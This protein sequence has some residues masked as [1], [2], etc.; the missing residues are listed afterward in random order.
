M[1]RQDWVTR[2]MKD[3]R[4]RRDRRYHCDFCAYTCDRMAK[5]ERHVADVHSDQEEEQE[6][7]AAAAPASNNQPAAPKR[8]ASPPSPVAQPQPKRQASGAAR[9]APTTTTPTTTPTTTTTTT[10]LAARPSPRQ[11]FY[12][13]LVPK[14]GAAG[15]RDPPVVQDR[16]T[17][18]LSL[19]APLPEVMPQLAPPRRVQEEDGDGHRWFRR[20]SPSPGHPRY[21]AAAA[22]AAAL[23]P[24]P[25]P[26]PAPA[27]APASATETEA[28]EEELVD[29]DEGVPV[30]EDRSRPPS[31]FS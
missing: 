16:S 5:L 9:A 27:R 1:V 24:A 19:F 28:A 25:A 17:G 26:T 21:R 29:P 2:Q 6:E 13:D 7:A 3:G 12:D 11:A 15:S 20:R 4:V 22:A 18:F 14:P 8:N 30:V 10:T 23:D 31:P